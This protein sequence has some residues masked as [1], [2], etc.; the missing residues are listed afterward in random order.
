MDKRIKKAKKQLPPNNSGLFIPMGIFFGLGIGIFLGGRFVAPALFIGMGLGFAL[1][2]YSSKKRHRKIIEL[3]SLQ[4]LIEK[5]EEQA[6]IEQK[7]TISLPNQKEEIPTYLESTMQNY[8]ELLTTIKQQA[9]KIPVEKRTVVNDIILL[10]KKIHEYV[11]ADITRYSSTKVFY[12]TYIVS[13]EN[14]LKTYV[15]LLEQPV[16]ND[17]ATESVKNIEK[18]LHEMKLEFEEAYVKLYEKDV[19][20]VNLE[21]EMIRNKFKEEKAPKLF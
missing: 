12:Q 17:S 2:M 8:E 3:Q 7:K 15:L 9:S 10:L 16:K 14:I 5:Q 20:N 21:M 18:I 1:M 11:T 13:L 6:V 4:E 19:M